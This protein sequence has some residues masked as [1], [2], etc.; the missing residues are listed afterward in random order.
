MPSL[1]IVAILTLIARPIAVFALLIPF[2]CSIK[3]CLLTSWS[4]LR[5]AASIVFSIMVVAGNP[6]ISLDIFH[7]VFMVALFSVSI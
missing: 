2:K 6:D 3:Q 7:I 4:G 1:C 5:G